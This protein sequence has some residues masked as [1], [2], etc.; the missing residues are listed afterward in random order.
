MSYEA[1]SLQRHQS[2]LIDARM[3][4]GNGT[5]TT[6][7]DRACSLPFLSLTKKGEIEDGKKTS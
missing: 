4:G 7:S 6:Q 2:L 3:M 5:L 1:P